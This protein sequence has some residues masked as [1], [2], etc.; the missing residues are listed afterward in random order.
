[1]RR[2]PR[3]GDWARAIVGP[4]VVW[5]LGIAVATA[6]TP[7]SKEASRTTAGFPG[8][9]NKAP[10][11]L[12]SK[13]PFDLNAYLASPPQAEDGSLL[14]LDALLEFTSET[15]SCL[16][17]D[18]ANRR[19]V[20]VANDRSK[21]AGD[22]FQAVV[23]LNARVPGLEAL[24]AEHAQGFK[25]IKQAQER[26]RCVFATG[27]GV[28]APLP[29]VEAT[30]QVGLVYILKT[31]LELQQRK[32]EDALDNLS[33]CL[34]LSRDLRPRGVA[35]TQLV[36][37]KLESVAL[38]EIL[39]RL[40][41][42]PNLTGEQVGKIIKVLADHEARAIDAYPEA[43]KAEAIATLA[44]IHDFTTRADAL[45]KELGVAPETPISD[46]FMTLDG[47][48]DLPLAKTAINDRFERWK[49]DDDDR[50]SE[51][52]FRSVQ[53][54]LAPNAQTYAARL[55]LGRVPMGDQLGDDPGLR[56]ILRE[57]V[58]S[59]HDVLDDLT[60]SVAELRGARCLAGLRSLELTTKARPTSLDAVARAAGM[61]AAPLDPFDGKPMRLVLVDQ[62]PVVY[63]VGKDLKD[64]GGLVDSERDGEPGDLVF[65]A[66][67]PSPR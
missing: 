44:K 28:V 2:S 11:W 52:V 10:G 47:P 55:A 58:P 64:D 33:V 59:G 46:L 34:R 57:L 65:R 13:A 17:A 66:I 63:S 27:L 62:V 4:G 9:I 36:S 41:A 15:A 49:P 60:R 26:P 42:E 54:Q 25:K 30:L 7:T 31:I 40:L 38:R 5:L 51:V 6:Q 61:D 24:M 16:P 35:I 45:R 50:V 23:D 22:L 39:P 67:T 8:G 48:L 20:Q 1:M 43:I 37:S 12:P 21:R 32:F 19:R 14:Y 53:V 56:T 18:E 3:I 29:H